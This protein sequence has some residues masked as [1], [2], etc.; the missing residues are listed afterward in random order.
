MKWNWEEVEISR[1]NRSGDCVL[2]GDVVRTTPT[3]PFSSPP[4]PS[5]LKP[6]FPKIQFQKSNS[7]NP[8]NFPFYSSRRVCILIPMRGGVSTLS[9]FPCSNTGQGRNNSPLAPWPINLPKSQGPM[10]FGSLNSFFFSLSNLVV[11]FGLEGWGWDGLA[12]EEWAWVWDWVFGAFLACKGPPLKGG[13]GA[14]IGR[15]VVMVDWLG[16]GERR[17]A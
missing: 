10:F 8:T 6:N 16:R 5:S 3:P 13:I 1:S 12:G 17:G 2:L 15:R 9:P 7:P 11:A 4:P 14:T